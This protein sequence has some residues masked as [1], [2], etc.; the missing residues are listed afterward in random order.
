MENVAPQG[1]GLAKSITTITSPEQKRKYVIAGIVCS[2]FGF[3][4][5]S[6]PLGTATLV[7]GKILLRNQVKVWGYAFCAIGTA[8]AVGLPLLHFLA[9]FKTTT[10]S[11]LPVIPKF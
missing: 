7:V 3:F 4:V 1:K 2:A 6:L 9:L 5:A 11:I 10:I 8:W